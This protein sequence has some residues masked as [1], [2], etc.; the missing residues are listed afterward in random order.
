MPNKNDWFLD[1]TEFD[2]L[3]KV[4]PTET[5]NDE[6]STKKDQNPSPEI[7]DDSDDY[8]I[9]QIVS[10]LS[11]QNSINKKNEDYLDPKL[12]NEPQKKSNNP[13]NLTNN[14]NLTAE[15]LR[16]F[17]SIDLDN[18]DFNSKF[19]L[20]FNDLSMMKA[21]AV[22]GLL[23]NTN[24]RFLAWMIFL[25]CIPMEK[26]E[27]I[28]SVKQ[29]RLHYE[30]IRKEF[31]CD[32]HKVKDNFDK[33]GIYD[34]P[35]SQNEKST[36]NKFFQ[37]K[38]IKSVIIQDVNRINQHSEYFALESTQD[39][40]VNL[41]FIYIQSLKLEYKQG[42]HE[43]LTCIMYVLHQEYT[44]LS[45]LTETNEIIEKIA[46]LNYIEHDSYTIFVA[47][48]L[49]IHNWFGTR[50][51]SKLGASSM[52]ESFTQ[53]RRNSLICLTP[54]LFRENEEFY[55]SFIINKINY[56]TK[57]VLQN[58]DIEVYN[59]LNLIGV[60]LHPFGIRWLRLLFLRELEFPQCLILWDAMFA[61]DNKE[62]GLVNYLFVA[63]LACLRDQLLKMD[64]S[65]CM[66]LLM[67]PQFY[68]DSLDVLKTAL[69]LQNPAIYQRP[70]SMENSY[71]YIITSS[72]QKKDISKSEYRTRSN[73]LM[74]S[75]VSS[76]NMTQ[77][78]HSNL[79]MNRSNSAFLQN[80]RDNNNN[81]Q[82]N[83]D[84]KV[85]TRI[86]NSFSNNQSGKKLKDTSQSELDLKRLVKKLDYDYSNLPRLKR[87]ADNSYEMGLISL[88]H[89]DYNSDI[90]AQAYIKKIQELQVEN[91]KL[92]THLKDQSNLCQLG[93]LKIESN[94]DLLQKEINDQ[95]TQLKEDDL[96]MLAID[97]LKQIS[98][99]LDSNFKFINSKDGKPP[100]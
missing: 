29:N 90:I 2:P 18:L 57:S 96:I 22:Q 8:I 93:A 97:G 12:F 95:S 67:Q 38:S 81:N 55:E 78:I 24:F 17:S 32:P 94:V 13:I 36:W 5:L 52:I 91:E 35:L 88:E 34:H 47:V 77:N 83:K 42:M 98:R 54:K 50:T 41:L 100:S 16:I 61:T 6:N 10:N 85:P 39:S 27:W 92:K 86:P 20:L 44:N 19:N 63:L 30:N 75:S 58:N 23:G 71:E 37:Q 40:I 7:L 82:Y 69:Y 51:T 49:R 87:S 60:S 9:T 80:D 74:M 68:L 31:S 53:N 33:N 4:C 46:N 45:K 89:I 65:S 62:L 25:E 59:H 14:H 56:I 15:T 72:Q 73:N 1:S 3:A 11:R 64:N 28:E 43:I 76:Q 79:H 70:N 48:M 84:N 21:T 99:Q 66:K 26:I